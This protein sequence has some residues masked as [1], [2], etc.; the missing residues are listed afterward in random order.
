MASRPVRR[1]GGRRGKREC[2]VFHGNRLGG[3]PGGCAAHLDSPTTSVLTTP[4]TATTREPSGRPPSTT[5]PRG[6]PRRA[7]G[8][9]FSSF[10]RLGLKRA[11]QEES[12]SQQEGIR[13]LPLSLS[14]ILCIFFSLASAAAAEEPLSFHLSSCTTRVCC[15]KPIKANYPFLSLPITTAITV[16]VSWTYIPASFARL[17]TDLVSQPFTGLYPCS[18]A[19]EPD[20]R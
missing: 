20:V 3:V 12:T 17:H 7:D 13:R 15:M 1:Q 2:C 6:C 5:W 18:S 10:P 8:V 9:G 11:I 19:V 14:P 4:P 16:A